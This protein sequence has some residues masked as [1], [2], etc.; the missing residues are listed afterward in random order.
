MPSSDVDFV[1][2]DSGSKADRVTSSSAAH[3]I[4]VEWSCCLNQR[5]LNQLF[6]RQA[7]LDWWCSPR[8]ARIRWGLPGSMRLFSEEWD[9][10][11]SA[12]KIWSREFAEA[13]ESGEGQLFEAVSGRKAELEAVWSGGASAAVK[14]QAA[15]DEAEQYTESELALMMVRRILVDANFGSPSD[16]EAALTMVK[17]FQSS[18]TRMVERA[19]AEVG[20][21]LSDVD[22]S[23]LVELVVVAFEEDVVA[24]LQSKG[25]QVSRD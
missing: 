23:E 8:E 18:V 20:Q 2:V 14:K 15:D 6:K 1:I 25:W 16:R 4:Y 7:F 3:L 22:T 17:S 24:T 10:G 5:A 19:I 9:L 13:L 12:P 11:A 21:D